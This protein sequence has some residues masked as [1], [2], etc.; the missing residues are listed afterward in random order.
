[1][2]KLFIGAMIMLSMSS[3][4]QDKRFTLSAYTE[5]LDINTHNDS[6]DYG[7]NLGVQIEYQMTIMYF[8]AEV[9]WVPDLNNLPYFH[10]QGTVLGFNHHFGG[11]DNDQFRIGLGVIKPGMVRRTRTHAM[12]GSD[13]NF[14][15][16]T[17][18]GLF[19]GITGKYDWRHDDKEWDSQGE[20]HGVWSLGG[21]IGFTF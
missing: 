4:S 1:M 18:T 19:F 10:F 21:R 11:L 9:F 17:D 5:A 15:W 14:E 3:F 6:Y 7:F 20:G 2:R 8:D 12:I 16:Y 13:L